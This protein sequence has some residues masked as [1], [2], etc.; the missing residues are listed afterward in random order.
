MA[1]DTRPT[2]HLGEQ[3]VES[4]DEPAGGPELMAYGS[5]PSMAKSD[6]FL[7]EGTPLFLSSDAA[8]PQYRGFG[9]GGERNLNG[10]VAWSKFIKAGILAISAAAITVAILSVENPLSLFAS[11]KASLIGVQSNDTAK[12]T[13][14]RG[15]AARPATAQPAPA[16]PSTVSLATL[17]TP[18]EA[19]PTRDQIALALRAAHQS[20]QQI[21][22]PAAAA[23]PA[24]QLDAGELATLLKRAMGLITIGDIAAARLLLERAADAQEA[25]AALLLAQT[26]DPAVLGTPDARS[27]T[28]DQAKARD[29]YRKAARFGSQD[30]QLR[31]SQMQN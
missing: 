16:T 19:A 9:S 6:Y 20:Q 3:A 26:Y 11:A 22:P 4:L 14:E 10:A 5:T 23:T 30:A 13:S 24:R 8:E 27:I 21:H 18:A 28:P 2:S 31:L 1:Q 29:W 25:S 12:S 7:P 17:P 15:A